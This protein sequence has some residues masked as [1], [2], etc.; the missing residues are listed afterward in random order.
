MQKTIHFALFLFLVT[1]MLFTGCEKTS[2]E[3]EE[4]VGGS[5]EESLEIGTEDS[6]S[7]ET[8]FEDFNGTLDGGENTSDTTESVYKDGTYSENATYMSPAGQD[9]MGVS[10]TLKDGVI[11]AVSIENLATNET[12]IQFQNLFAEGISSVVVGKPIASLG[13][14]GA[15]NG[16]SLTPVGFNAAV[17]AIMAD[18]QQ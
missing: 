13:K 14:V 2:T 18:A 6:E 7:T 1:G 17:E 15:V 11:T 9:T 5:L 3:T 12:S 4:E 8:N 10:L 16:S